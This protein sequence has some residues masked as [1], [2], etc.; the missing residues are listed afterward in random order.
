MYRLLLI[1]IAAGTPMGLAALFLW[2]NH[3]RTVDLSFDLWMAAWH[4]TSPVSVSVLIA[5]CTLGGFLAGVLVMF[6]QGLGARRR[7]TQ[8]ERELSMSSLSGGS[9]TSGPSS[10]SAGD[11]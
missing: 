3:A 4:L 6:I 10:S 1:V 7:A 5:A 2:Q 11:W 9:A 8:R